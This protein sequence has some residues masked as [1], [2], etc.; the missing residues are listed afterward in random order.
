MLEAF[1]RGGTFYF[2]EAGHHNTGSHEQSFDMDE[3]EENLL[4]GKGA[5][6]KRKKMMVE[7][8]LFRRFQKIKL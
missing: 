6:K 7:Y 8:I 5:K 2:Q 4:D 1:L 3:E